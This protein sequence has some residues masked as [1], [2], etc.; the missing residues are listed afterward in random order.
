MIDL[1]KSDFLYKHLTKLGVDN[2]EE[3]YQEYAKN[4]VSNLKDFKLII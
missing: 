4:G 3:T 1:D 2:L